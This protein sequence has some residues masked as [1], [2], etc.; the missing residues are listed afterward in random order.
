MSGR[1]SLLNHLYDICTGMMDKTTSVN[2]LYITQG[3][4]YCKDGA[5]NIVRKFMK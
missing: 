2:M 5:I 3:I 4:S 1:N